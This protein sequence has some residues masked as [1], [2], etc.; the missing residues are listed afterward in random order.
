MLRPL[1]FALVLALSATGAWADRYSDCNQDKDYDRK[2]RGCTQIIERGKRESIERRAVAYVN[3]GILYFIQGE[4]DRAF[5]DYTKAIEI[6]PNLATPYAQRAF[7]YSIKGNKEQA[8]ADA[9]KAL[10]IEP[11]NN[12]AKNVLT[13]WGATP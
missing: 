7:V 4:N 9:R 13:L 3:R 11:S 6:N 10:E 5:A 12:V 2:F 8:I 1:V